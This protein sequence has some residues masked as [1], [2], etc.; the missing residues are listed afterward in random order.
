MG[1]FLFFCTWVI[2][3][4][5]TH[6]YSYLFAFLLQTNILSCILYMCGLWFYFSSWLFLCISFCLCRLIASQSATHGVFN[7]MSHPKTRRTGIT[8]NVVWYLLHTAK[9]VA[10]SIPAHE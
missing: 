5:P 9:A 4:R 8:C 3:Y 6:G 2:E 10:D 1:T 7:I